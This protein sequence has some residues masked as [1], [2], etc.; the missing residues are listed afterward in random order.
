MKIEHHLKDFV[1]DENFKIT[2]NIEMDAMWGQLFP[3]FQ[4]NQT[5]AS[6]HRFSIR[7]WAFFCAK[8]W[9]GYNFM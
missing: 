5:I 2:L 4:I 7:F 3:L 1:I 6:P 8:Q 9:W